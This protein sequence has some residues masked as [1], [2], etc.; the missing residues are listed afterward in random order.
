MSQKP[1]PNSGPLEGPLQGIRVLEFG[2]FV[3]GPWA[4]QLLADMGAD[5]IKVE[6]PS[7]DPWRHANPFA[8]NESRVFV[9][10]NRGVRS[11]C[12]DLKQELARSVLK[13]LIE[14]AD[15]VVSNNRVDTAVK[16]GIDYATVSKINPQLV[17]VDITAY[18]PNGPRADMPGFDLILQGYTGAVTSEGK[19]TDGQPEVVWSSSYIDLSTGYAAANGI[20]AGI[21]GRGKTG[22]GQLVSTSLLGNA[23]AMQTLRVADIEGMP[24]PARTWYDNV[25]PELTRQGASYEEIQNSYQ[26]AV[27][28]LIYRCYYRAYRTLDGGLTLGTLAVH[29]RKRLLDVFGLKDPRVTDPEYDDSTPEATEQGKRLT[30][31]FEEIFA[32]K[33]TDHWFKKLRAHDIPCDPIRYVEEMIEDEQVLANRYVIELDHHTGHKIRTSGPILRFEDGMPPEN[34]SSPA[35]GEHTDEVLADIGYKPDEIAELRSQGSVT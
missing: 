29:A 18:G 23:I 11:I 25:Y 21:I 34:K 5:V 30:M 8:P 27:R 31:E 17:Y 35:L 1:V 3:A 7:G 14:S 2:S 22:R 6:P 24:A 16:L 20:L 15:G 32:G 12:L 4:G 33:T 10:L 19:M 13:K 26:Q 9:P 28:P